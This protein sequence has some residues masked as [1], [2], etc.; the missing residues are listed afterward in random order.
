MEMIEEEDVGEENRAV[1][2]QGA[3]VLRRGCGLVMKWTYSVPT[4]ARLPNPF[5][6]IGQEETLLSLFGKT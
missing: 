4:T 2:C 5:I 6:F 3:V 1:V